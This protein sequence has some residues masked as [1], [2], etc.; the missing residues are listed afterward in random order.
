M[1]RTQVK[2]VTDLSDVILRFVRYYIKY[3]FDKEERI[4]LA[5]AAKERSATPNSR[6]LR[7]SR[8]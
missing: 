7:I 6:C 8:E 2:D 5:I 3:F 4:V 1:F